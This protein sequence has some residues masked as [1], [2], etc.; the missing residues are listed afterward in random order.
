MERRHFLKLAFGFAAGGVALAA[1]AQA[2][3]LMPAPLA[4]DTKL[5]ANKDA[6]PAVTT[7]KEVE[8]LSPEEV[9]WGRGRGHRRGWGRRRWGWRRRRWRR[10]YW[11]WHRRRRRWRRRYWRRRYYW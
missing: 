1:S 6:Q 9:K 10:R 7:G 4:D 8:R 11:G 5:P 2:A 3:P